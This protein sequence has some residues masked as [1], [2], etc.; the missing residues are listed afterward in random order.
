[1]PR[2]RSARS[3]F[4]ALSQFALFAVVISTAVGAHAHGGQHQEDQAPQVLAPGYA[5]L[6][7]TAPP[8]GSY[9]LPAVGYASDGEVLASSGEPLALASLLGEKPV[10]MSF[11]YTTC[12]D[13]NGCPL[14]TFVMSQ[15]ANRIAADKALAGKVRMISLSFDPRHDTPEVMRD[16]GSNFRPDGAR[17]C[18]SRR[19]FAAATSIARSRSASAS[20]GELRRNRRSPSTAAIRAQP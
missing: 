19:P 8:V 4:F 2:S 16:Y 14:A 9:E 17:N 13:V 18:S 10:L 1:M 11:V 6:S 15:V 12:D 20:S 7:F 5:E 3:T